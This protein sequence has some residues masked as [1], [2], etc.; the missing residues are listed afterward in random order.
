VASLPFAVLLLSPSNSLRQTDDLQRGGREAAH[1]STFVVVVQVGA[2][3]QRW[4]FVGGRAVPFAS[5]W[6]RTHP[7][8]LLSL[9]ESRT[10]VGHSAGKRQRMR[11]A[12]RQTRRGVAGVRPTLFSVV[13]DHS[14]HCSQGLSWGMNGQGVSRGREGESAA[15]LPLFVAGRQPCHPKTQGR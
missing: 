1:T 10:L 2:R 5:H 6:F 4:L 9:A 7:S 15:G 13:T 12:G 14:R 3:D 11:G 8:A